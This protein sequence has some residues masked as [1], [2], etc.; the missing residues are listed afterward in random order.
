[1]TKP[2]AL[3]LASV[4]LAVTSAHTFAAK[5]AQP[6]QS[7]QEDVSLIKLEHTLCQAEVHLYELTL[8]NAH[9]MAGGDANK[10]DSS[11]VKTTRCPELGAAKVKA[12]YQ[13]WKRRAK[14]ASQREALDNWRIVWEAA[15]KG[16]WEK[17]SPALEIE[18]TKA[19][20]RLEIA[21]E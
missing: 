11:T 20:T 10:I 13:R 3:I 17:R 5:P 8:E 12:T 15:F 21:F 2:V 16:L 18:A 6:A 14:S 1:M 9:M 4:A 19:S 7:I